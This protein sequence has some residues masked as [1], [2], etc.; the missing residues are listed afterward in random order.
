MLC[1]A[2][3]VVAA[4]NAFDHDWQSRAIAQPVEIVEAKV[5][6]EIIPHIGSE[7]GTAYSRHGPFP[8]WREIFDS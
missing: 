3:R 5:G 1:R 7:A 2:T 8:K 6:L 4:T